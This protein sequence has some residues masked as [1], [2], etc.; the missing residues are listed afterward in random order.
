VPPSDTRYRD[1][2]PIEYS[3][4]GEALW[5]LEKFCSVIHP[6][7]CGSLKVFEVRVEAE[8]RFGREEGVLLGSVVD[9]SQAKDAYFS[10]DDSALLS[11][12]GPDLRGYLDR[13]HR[14]LEGYGG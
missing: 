6:E 13:I 4:L 3:R 10:Y 8:E 5:E 1:E 7:G 2:Y 9:D 14:L 12:I 11:G